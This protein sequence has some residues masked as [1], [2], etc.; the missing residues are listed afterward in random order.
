MQALGIGLATQAGG[1]AIGA[2]LG[3]LTTY[4][5]NGMQLSQNQQLLN[6]Q[7]AYNE[8]LS[9]FNLGLQEKLWQDTNYP[10]QVQQMKDAGINPAMMFAKGMGTGG[11]YSS[12]K[13]TSS[14]TES[15]IEYRKYDVSRTEG[16]SASS[17]D[18]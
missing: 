9:E 16:S 15:G 8:N 4:L 5:G 2:G 6:Q 11:K 3:L 18:K 13:P 10:A 12:D 7:T 14:T 17:Y 1:A